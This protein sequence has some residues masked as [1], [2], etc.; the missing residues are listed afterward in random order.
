MPGHGADPRVGN[1]SPHLEDGPP[2]AGNSSTDR[3]VQ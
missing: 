1:E 3:V 2:G